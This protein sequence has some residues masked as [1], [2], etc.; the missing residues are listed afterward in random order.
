MTVSEAS[1]WIGEINL[2]ILHE[3]ANVTRY[4]ALDEKGLV[5]PHKVY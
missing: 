5:L 2:T 1:I 4:Y 3:E